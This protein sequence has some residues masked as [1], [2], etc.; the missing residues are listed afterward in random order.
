MKALTTVL[1]LVLL[2]PALALGVNDGF[3]CGQRIVS[4]G[5]RV[6]E[7]ARKCPEPFWTE[8][9]DRPLA[10]D[11][12]GRPLALARVEVW[13]LNFGASHFM[14][15]LEFVNGR[16]SRVRDLGY[17]VDYEPGSRRCGPHELAQAGKTTAEVFAR[18]GLPDY[19]YEVPSPQ[20]YG[21]FGG[22]ARQQGERRVWTYEFGPRRRP[23]E[24]LFVDGRLQ[25][26]SIP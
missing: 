22:S 25:R 23:R 17:G 13:A 18:C 15:R 1:G 21:Y 7:V 14:R 3:Y 26:L 8:S 24:L 11:R 2:T 6:W 10:A 9:Y 19:S 4:V 16:L 12:H 20:H 5:D